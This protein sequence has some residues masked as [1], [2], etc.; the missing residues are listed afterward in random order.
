ML[1]RIVDRAPWLAVVASIALFS[2]CENLQPARDGTAVEPPRYFT[3]ILTGE[4]DFID[5]DKGKNAI[6]FYL[7]GSYSSPAENDVKL[8]QIDVYGVPGRAGKK[9]DLVLLANIPGPDAPNRDW[10]V[11]PSFPHFDPKKLVFDTGGLGPKEKLQDYTV[12]LVFNYQYTVGNVKKTG[13]LP[14]T[15]WITTLAEPTPALPMAIAKDGE[16]ITNLTGS[17]TFYGAQRLA[18]YDFEVDFNQP[19]VKVEAFAGSTIDPTTRIYTHPFESPQTNSWSDTGIVGRYNGTSDTYFFKVVVTMENGTTDP[20]VKKFEHILE[21][22]GV[23][24]PL[25]NWVPID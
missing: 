5:L 16:V 15:W 24:I 23:P 1:Q 12:R 6:R 19:I 7:R 20:A 18:L 13:T 17:G 9:K 8:V 10:E 11:V 2:S 21:N 3:P 4:A 14:R 25:S 22:Q